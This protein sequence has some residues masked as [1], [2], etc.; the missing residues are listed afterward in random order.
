MR[1]INNLTTKWEK[2]VPIFTSL[3]E[4]LTRITM[5]LI[6]LQF[7]FSLLQAYSVTEEKVYC[8]KSLT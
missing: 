6:I 4:G 3:K 5:K 7:A 1:L 2:S 8:F